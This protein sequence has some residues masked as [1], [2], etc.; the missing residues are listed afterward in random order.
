MGERWKTPPHKTRQFRDSGT[1]EAGNWSTDKSFYRSS[2]MCLPPGGGA[3]PFFRIVP[4]RILRRFFRISFAFTT[5][6]VRFGTRGGSSESVHKHNDQTADRPPAPGYDTI[7]ETSMSSYGHMEITERFHHMISDD[8]GKSGNV[9]YA[10][11]KTLKHRAY[12]PR[13]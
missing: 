2:I 8:D 13:L 4:P 11:D 6:G 3:D 7:V 10:F 1:E 5:R 9:I 12:L